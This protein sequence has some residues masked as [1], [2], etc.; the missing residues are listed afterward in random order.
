MAKFSEM[1]KEARRMIDEM[2]TIEPQKIDDSTEGRVVPR[3]LLL[4]VAANIASKADKKTRLIV[5]EMITTPNGIPPENITEEQYFL[6][7]MTALALEYWGGEPTL[8][9]DAAELSAALGITTAELQGAAVWIKD[10]A[11]EIRREQD[12]QAELPGI[13]PLPQETKRRLSVDILSQ[14]L[15][16]PTSRFNRDISFYE[17]IN[18]ATMPLDISKNTPI[19]KSKNYITFSINDNNMPITPLEKNIEGV[20]SALVE[21]GYK[22]LTPAQIFCRAN[23]ITNLH[24][25]KL[26]RSI[27]EKIVASVEN[28]MTKKMEFTITKNGQTKDAKGTILDVMTIRDRKTGKITFHFNR[29]GLLFEIE[30]WQ[31]RQISIA[32]NVL[33]LGSSGIQVTPLTMTIR[34]FCLEEATRIAAS[35]SADIT[36]NKFLL[37]RFYTIDRDP[38]LT[39]KINLYDDNGNPT[40]EIKYVL[41]TGKDRSEKNKINGA[42]K[43]R[44]AKLQEVLLHLQRTG[45]IKGWYFVNGAK[46]IA[47]KVAQDEK[48]GLPTRRYTPAELATADGVYLDVEKTAAAGKKIAHKAQEQKTIAAAK[49]AAKK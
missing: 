25:Q 3:E 22:D 46:K 6:L 24:G 30:K 15:L 17:N 31:G 38:S 41:K 9:K 32:P 27:E 36:S 47:Y 10:T 21:Q 35:G 12:E 5:A 8:N 29:T 44:L 11:A 20:A 43:Y 45:F 4:K 1:E 18:N 33:N 16:K 23:G 48:T 7:R 39:E 19:E 2:Q 28:M 34:E 13:E 49:R 14:R 26:N 42:K 37:E 40:G